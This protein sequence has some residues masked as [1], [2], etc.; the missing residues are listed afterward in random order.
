MRGIPLK[1]LL[2]PVSYVYEHPRVLNEFYFVLITSDGYKVAF[3]WNE[4]YNTEAGDQYFMVT[5]LKGQNLQ[6]LEQRIIFVST[7][8]FKTGRRY[9]KGL[10]SI[11]ARQL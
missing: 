4:I 7:A 3:S 1:T 6:D 2:N 10:K 8:N 9:I 11:E 5:E